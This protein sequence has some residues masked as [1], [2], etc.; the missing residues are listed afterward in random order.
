MLNGKKVIK[1]LFF[2][3]FLSCATKISA[4]RNSVF[5]LKKEVIFCINNNFGDSYYENK[6]EK[7]AFRQ[8]LEQLEADPL[9]IKN[10]DFV[11]DFPEGVLDVILQN[12]YWY[13]VEKLGLDLLIVTFHL[14]KHNNRLSEKEFEKKKVYYDKLH[15]DLYEACD[16]EE[17]KQNYENGVREATSQFLRGLSIKQHVGNLFA[18]FAKQCDICG[19]KGFC[20]DWYGCMA[21]KA[22]VHEIE[23]DVIEIIKKRTKGNEEA[24]EKIYNQVIKKVEEH[25]GMSL[26]EYLDKNGVKQF[27]FLFQT[28]GCMIAESYY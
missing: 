1:F 18:P 25:G 19:K 12:Q 15:D 16:E 23:K 13:I 20:F 26:K 11:R 24:Y 10:D 4:V 22:C 2:V 5:D 27:T 8:K 3:L 28:T 17:K 9:L 14:G 7:E 21:H 6:E